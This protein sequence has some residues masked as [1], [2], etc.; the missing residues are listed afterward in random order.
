MSSL[1][2]IEKRYFN[3]LFALGSGYVISQEAYNNKTFAEF[4]RECAKININAEKYSFNGSS[5]AKRLRAFWEIESDHIT[6]KVLEALLEVWSYENPEPDPSTQ[7][8]YVRSK[9]TVARLQGKKLVEEQ[10]EDDFLRKKLPNIDVSQIGLSSDLLEVTTHR[11]DEIMS[12]MTHGAPLAAIL[13]SGSVLEGILLD[14]AC[15]NPRYFNQAKCAPKDKES[16]VRRF[17]DWSLSELI[18]AAYELDFIKLD[19]KKFS[20][21]LRDFRNYIHPHEQALARFQPTKHTADIC[22]QV[23]KAAVAELADA[24]ARGLSH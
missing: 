15:K 19:V 2:S 13:L 1:N 7:K 18:N 11:L 17:P 4:F 21:S 5:K 8:A 9:T 12:C 6:G 3:D 23:L 14:L 20:H 10:T 22:F 24:K 16:A